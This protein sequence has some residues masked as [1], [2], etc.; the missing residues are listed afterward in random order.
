MKNFTARTG[1]RTYLTAFAGVEELDIS[2]RT[3]LFRIAQE[4]LTNVGRHAH[5]T[6]ADLTIQKMPDG[7]CM[8]IKDDGKSFQVDRVLL[9]RGKRLG[10]IGMR[11][12]LE[13]VGGHFEIESAPG[14]G[15]T[16][17]AQLPVG[18]TPTKPVAKGRT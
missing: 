4:A 1:V 9:R 16:I 10:L 3:T 14:H 7:V 8:K 15:T 5:A 13:M 2:R 6:R 17:T 18:S 12:R 11:E